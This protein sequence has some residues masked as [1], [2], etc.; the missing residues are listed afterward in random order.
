VSVDHVESADQVESASNDA[1]DSTKSSSLV[2][3][4]GPLAVALAIA[5]SGLFVWNSAANSDAVAVGE[6]RDQVLIA[7]TKHIETLNTLDYRDVEKGLKGWQAVTTG[8]LNDQFAALED[9]NRA[10]LADQKKISVGKVTDAAVLSL[11]DNTA[12]V[13]AAVEITVSD[14]AKKGSEPTVKR[15]R[16][17]ADMVKVGN[18]W[19]TENLKQVAVS[20]S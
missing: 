18:V 19:K 17:S 20:L 7:G 13:V 1:A 3:T 8:T 2:R 6:E 5:V 9:D 12:T 11:D 16:F 15:N 4:W 10:W 14:D